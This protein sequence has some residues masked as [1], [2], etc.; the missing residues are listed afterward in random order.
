[1]SAPTTT[2]PP[3]PVTPTPVTTTAV[4][5]PT[6]RARF[7]RGRT[8]LVLAG[9]LVAG[10]IALVAIQ[11]I[12][13]PAGAVLGADNPAPT[14]AKAVVE[15]L[16]AQGVEVEAVADLESALDAARDGATVLV[17]DEYGMLDGERWARL[18]DAA[19]RLVVVDPTFAALAEIAPGVRNA[20]TAVGALDDPDCDVPAAGRAGVLSEGQGLLRVDDEAL[21]AGWRACFPD[22]DAGV[23]LAVGPADGGGEL[24]LV[25]SPALFANDTVDEAGNAALALGLTGPAD[26]LAWY[27]PGPADADPSTAPTLGELTPGWTTPVIVLLVV[28]TIAAGIHH[29]RRFGPLV[30]EDLPVEVRSGE[31]REGR[32]RLYARSASRLHA[33][34]QL[35]MGTVRRLAALLRLPRTAEVAAVAAATAEAT[36]RDPVEVRRILVDDDPAGD[37]RFVDLAAALG[38]LED[39]VRAAIRPP[40]QTPPT[41]S[42][43]TP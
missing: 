8:W 6:L 43:R 18:A 39:E 30:V 9:I 22:G 42:G 28:V 10:A 19:E 40:G 38:D 3:T 35:R 5:T 2:A 20:G 12:A 21:D 36:G 15:V 17:Y 24:A 27:L 1:M 11:G 31:T 4:E 13:R 29:G 33:L 25:P 16:G 23:A 34:D 37:R 41:R 7:R 26:R 32:A 14:G